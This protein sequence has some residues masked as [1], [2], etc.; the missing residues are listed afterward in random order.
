M[1]I[2][3]CGSMT[4]SKEMLEIENN[5]KK[6]GHEV[7]T[8]EFTANYTRLDNTNTLYAES[9][10]NKVKHDLIRSHFKKI[11]MSDAILVVNVEKKDVIGYIGGNSF[12]E[13]GFAFGINKKIYLLNEIPKLSYTDELIAMEPIII[14]GDLT[15]IK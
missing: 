15:I 6:L 10:K 3:I 13:M 11:E 14:N 1:K 5:L 12:L 8:P 7:L 9:T 4:A 2:T